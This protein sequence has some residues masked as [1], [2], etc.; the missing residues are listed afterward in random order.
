MDGNKT[1]IVEK[2]IHYVMG[3]GNHARSYLHRTPEGK[4][5]QLPVSWY[6][7]GGG[8]WA[9]SPGYDRP[10]HQGF[11][12]EIGYDCMFCHNA[13]PDVEADAGAHGTPPVFPAAIREGIGCQRCHG[14]G[15]AHLE[16]VNAA[17]AT[18]ET[19]R[20]SIVN[21]AR[22]SPER[23]LDVCLQCHLESTSQ[24]LPDS[25]V[26]FNREAF[27]YRQGEPLGDYVLHFDHPA[28]VEADKFEINHAAYRLLKA[29]CFQKSGGSMTCGTCHDPHDIPRGERAVRHYT[30]VCRGC[31]ES[32]LTRLVELGSHAGSDNC[33]PC[34]MPK[35]RA[36]DVVH[37]VMTDHYIQARSTQRDL[38]APL[39]ERRRRDLAYQGEIVRYYPRQEPSTPVD[40]LYL[41]AAQVIDGT[42]LLR[43]IPR[44]EGLL[45]KQQPDRAEFYFVLAE[46]YSKTGDA[47][48]AIAAYEQALRRA[49]GYLP[50]LQ[51]LGGT[52]LR[53]GRLAEAVEV[54]QR[55]IANAPSDSSVLVDLGSAY[56]QQQ[57]WRDAAQAAR[58]ALEQNPDLP[59]A[60]NNLGLALYA[61]G[62]R[63]C[64]GGR[65]P[66]SHPSPARLRRRAHQSGQQLSLRPA[67]FRRP[68]TSLKGPLELDPQQ[69]KGTL[70]LCTCAAAK[71]D[72]HSRR[73]PQLLADG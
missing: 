2:E 33:L 66:P 40:E 71:R 50:A 56:L 5:V 43:G 41:A 20:A 27:S 15:Q 44:L 72:V 54:L 22:L 59:Q 35:R 42:N 36:E 9:M 25:V 13:Y 7:E 60:A 34:H 26:R 45:R 1:N 69:Q 68:T 65:V 70:Q 29:A 19:A 49:P 8:H 38:L 30:A 63:Q 11:R 28:T 57:S 12:R 67:V 17:G 48:R 51:N 6:A 52:L 21:P 46:A 64:S 73:N 58:R 47:E 31:H 32:D 62:N 14:P 10:D 23:Q 24:P 55:A 4:L 39:T 53:S 37:V 18:V 16:A 61:H 3:S